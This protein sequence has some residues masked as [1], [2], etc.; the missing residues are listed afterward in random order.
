MRGNE[1]LTIK[2]S[3]PC[4]ED[5]VWA[6]TKDTLCCSR[7]DYGLFYEEDDVFLMVDNTTSPIEATG[8]LPD[9]LKEYDERILIEEGHYVWETFDGDVWGEMRDHIESEVDDW[10]SN[11]L[12]EKGVKKGTDEFSY[13]MFVY[14]N[15]TQQNI[16]DEVWEDCGHKRGGT[17]VWNFVD[18]KW[19]EDYEDWELMG[20]DAIIEDGDGYFIADVMN[21][22][23]EGEHLPHSAELLKLLQA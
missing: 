5:I 19:I 18:G 22:V 14:S 9:F 3:N 12:E 4:W 8:I 23:G 10:F 21:D 13:A 20:Y 15:S 6:F 2:F 7:G 16:I 11:Y 17:I 1:R